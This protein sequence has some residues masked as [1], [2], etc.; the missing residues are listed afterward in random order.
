MDIDGILKH[1]YFYQKDIIEWRFYGNNGL[2]GDLA[3]WFFRGVPY[4][5]I[6][7]LHKQELTTT[8]EYLIGGLEHFIFPYGNVIIPTDELHHFSEG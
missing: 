4:S 6:W 5:T 3:V 8:N 7:Y 2:F 1:L